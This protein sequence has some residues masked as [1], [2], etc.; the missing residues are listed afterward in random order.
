[1]ATIKEVARKA[2]VSVGTVSNVLRGSKRV[3]PEVRERVDQAIRALDYHPNQIARSLKTRQTRLLGIIISDIANP[4]FPQMV[5]GAEDAALKHGYLLI[6]SNTDDQVEREKRVMAV[7]RTQ[8]VDGIL[9]VVAPNDTDL[10]HIR[11]TLASKIPLVCLD[12]IPPGLRIHSVTTDAVYGAEMCMRHL[13]SLGHRRIGIITG[14][15]LLRT[16]EDRLKGYR[17]ALEEAGLPIDPGLILAGD[18][19]FESGYV[20]TKQ[21]MLGGKCPTALFVANCM[22]GLGALKAIKELGLRCP[23]DL[24]LAVFDELPGNGSF[25]P[26]ITTVIQPA[27]EIGRQGAEMLIRHIESGEPQQPVE[28]RLM[29][30]LHIRESTRPR[31]SVASWPSYARSAD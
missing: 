19:R 22:M 17:N 18:F 13:I 11:N 27:Y 21:L 26:E 12:R 29:P 5:R 16:A 2:G 25:S 14:N 31:G 7:L 3:S 6:A 4:F 9:L 8:R 20:L 23:E 30:E 24:A 28:I 10:A 15:L 1:M